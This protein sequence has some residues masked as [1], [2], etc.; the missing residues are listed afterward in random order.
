[1]SEV[2][3][4]ASDDELWDALEQEQGEDTKGGEARDAAD[5]VR[6]C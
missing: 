5:A 2:V 6:L 4:M 3:C 1:M